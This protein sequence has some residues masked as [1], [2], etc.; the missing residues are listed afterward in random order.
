MKK[1]TTTLCLTLTLLLGSVGM[2]NA[3]PKCEGN[4]NKNTW[5]N[6]FGTRTSSN[7]AKYVG[8]FKDGLFYGQGTFTF[9]DGGKYI[10]EYKNGRWN[11]QGILTHGDG[12][13]YVGEW[14][15]GQNQLPWS[16]LVRG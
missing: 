3:L 1:L 6:C 15:L 13:K 2:S 7:E 8:E 14:Y 16:S 10:G 4:Y 9:P 12:T 5:T 11:G